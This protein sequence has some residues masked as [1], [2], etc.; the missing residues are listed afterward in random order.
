MCCKVLSFLVMLDGQRKERYLRNKLTLFL[1]HMPQEFP[2]ETTIALCVRLVRD[3]A[4][5]ENELRVNSEK[6]GSMEQHYT[7]LDTSKKHLKE[8]H[9]QLGELIRENQKLERAH[10][11]AEVGADGQRQK[12]QSLRQQTEMTEYYLCLLD[13]QIEAALR[14]EEVD[15]RERHRQQQQQRSDGV[16]GDEADDEPAVA[17]WT[18]GEE[19]AYLQLED[20]QVQLSSELAELETHNLEQ[21][22]TLRS[23]LTTLNE[24]ET[25]AI[26][27]RRQCDRLAEEAERW[28]TEVERVMMLST[29]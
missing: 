7:V 2:L 4:D 8:L 24:A 28:R 9:K 10:D 19:V 29:Q 17:S 26:E 18:E 3:I 13:R 27:K 22:K 6:L 25:A 1:K 16:L 15:E 5:A 21:K 12:L 20:A 14:T 23:M 11:E